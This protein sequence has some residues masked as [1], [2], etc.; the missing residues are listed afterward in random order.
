MAISTV[1]KLLI[2][3]EADAAQLQAELAKAGKQVTNFG[4]QSASAGKGAQQLGVQVANSA[5]QIVNAA[6]SMARAGKVGSAGIHAIAQEG[7]TL[8]GLFGPTGALVGAVS[9]TTLAIAQLFTDAETSAAAAVA[10]I[11]DKLDSLQNAN[12]SQGLHDLAKQLFVGTP[13]KNFEDGIDSLSK[14]LKA[15]DEQITK[16][17]NNPIAVRQANAISQFGSEG[18]MAAKIGG[19]GGGPLGNELLQLQEQRGKIAKELAQV[20]AQ[21]EATRARINNAP[22]PKPDRTTL[23]VQITTTS[24]KALAEAAKK[25]AEEIRDIELSFNTLIDKARLGDVTLVEFAHSSAVLSN[26]FAKLKGTTAEQQESFRILRSRANDAQ[27]ILQKITTQKA[28]AE[29]EQLKASMTPKIADDLRLAYERLRES[30]AKQVLSGLISP[31]EAQRALAL[32]AALDDV[33]VGAQENSEAIQRIEETA[34]SKMDAELGILDRLQSKQDELRDLSTSDLG[35]A[36]DESTQIRIAGLKAQIAELV[37]ELAKLGGAVPAPDVAT[38]RSFADSLS[39]AADAAFGISTALLGADDRLTRMLGSAA[40]IAGGFAKIADLANKTKGGFEGL[41]SSGSGILSVLPALGGI[42]GGVG[43]LVSGFTSKSPEEQERL[44]ALKANSERLKELSTQL[45]VSAQLSVSGRTQSQVTGALASSGITGATFKADFDHAVQVDLAMGAFLKQLNDLGLS[46][47][48]VQRIARDLNITIKDAHDFNGL[49]ALGVELKRLNELD[50]QAFA[51]SFAGQLQQLQLSFDLFP[52]RFKS[53]ADKFA[54]F[55]AL[56]NDP[57]VGAPALFGVFKG[58]DTSTIEGKQAALKQLQELFEQ[59][60]SGKI[61]PELRQGLNIQELLN[62]ISQLRAELGETSP[63]VRSASEQFSDAL[64]AYGLAVD[65]GTMTVEERLTNAKALFASLFPELAA[66][67]DTSSIE[68]FKSSVATIIDGFAADGELSE[69]ERA[70]IEVLK[71]LE[72]AYAGATSEIQK[73]KDSIDSL[74]LKNRFRGNDPFA[75]LDDLLA[76]FASRGRGKFDPTLGG[77]DALGGLTGADPIARDIAKFAQQFNLKTKDGVDAF[78]DAVRKAFDTAALDGISADE[79]RFFNG[80]G[81]ILDLAQSGVEAAATRAANDAKT[82]RQRILD[83]AETKIEVEDIT[84]PA[85]QL[86]IRFNALREAVPALAEA[87]GDFDTRTQE[88][89]DA[90]E[91]WIRQAVESP[92]ALAALS[93]ATGLSVEE[94]V[95]ALLG[96]ER[97]ADSA[98]TH[99]R[100]L[101]EQLQDAFSELDFSL[102]LENITDPV[103]RLQRTVDAIG[104][105]LPQIDQALKGINLNTPEGRQ[106]ANTALIALGRSTQDKTLQDAILK[107]LDVLRAVPVPTGESSSPAADQPTTTPSDRI[108]SGVTG[109]TE[110]TGNKLVE[111]TE[112]GVRQRGAILDILRAFAATG[113]IRAPVIPLGGIGGMSVHFSLGSLTTNINGAITGTTP[114]AIADAIL[115]KQAEDLLP[116][117]N[118][119]L[120]EKL[121][122]YRRTLGTA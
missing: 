60:T 32:Q 40:Q 112:A 17:K 73:N 104:A 117:L 91:A 43:A 59:L 22:L 55:I 107:I 64:E 121:L 76:G 33:K 72:Q 79:E 16:L 83:A 18:A 6:D 63:I 97:G 70:Q 50:F 35:L 122:E 84:D 2:R 51:N 85:E 90:L 102:H 96:M 111:L 12:D 77:G 23:P 56:L 81:D 66:S 108:Q 74:S 5:T 7:A 94:L 54:A 100:T 103:D 116:Y 89:R 68:S 8:A 39:D 10:R 29:F 20:E 3:I 95:N 41:F 113:T 38:A 4:T 98:A 53:D 105:V 34:I 80:L 42:V 106:Q 14:R 46:F 36:G 30:L 19:G 88:G 57:K 49:H 45:G 47:N 21:F 93:T 82:V 26:S 62:A 28:R 31:E 92:A 58:I 86:T 11:K 99:I 61:G 67:I 120:A 52:Q 27:Q 118:K 25:R 109:L 69:A 15:L 48:D 87:M 65:M 9:I 24:P 37:A 78:R 114:K 1:E 115:Q 75:E 13:S 101:A 71:A 110:R 119:Q 44:E